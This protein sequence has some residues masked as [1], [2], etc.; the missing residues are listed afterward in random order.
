MVKKTVEKREAYILPVVIL[1]IIFSVVMGMALLELGTTEN[2]RAKRS[3]NREKAFYLAEAGVNWAIA[4]ETTLVEDTTY[5]RSLGDG[6]FSV[7]LTGPYNNRKIESVGTAG[8]AAETVRFQRKEE[9]GQGFVYFDE[10]GDNVAGDV[11]MIDREGDKIPFHLTK[12]NRSD[13]PD[14][15]P[16]PGEADFDD[17]WESEGYSTYADDHGD[18]H[19]G[20]NTTITL[21]KGDHHFRSIQVSGTQAKLVLQGGTRVFIEKDVQLAGGSVEIEDDAEAI[22][23]DPWD[24]GVVIYMAEGV[25]MM[26]TGALGIS[27]PSKMPENFRIFS[28]SDGII[29]FPSSATDFYGIIYA[30]DATVDLVQHTDFHGSIVANKIEGRNDSPLTYYERL[31][32]EEKGVIVETWSKP[33][34]QAHFEE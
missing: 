8:R 32:D 22:V 28:N 19:V 34:W 1:L 27:N 3:G 24:D 15:L 13:Y 33:G 26:V 30:P 31:G 9:G 7:F 21:T 4:Q 16:M 10:D 12:S 20:G 2:T 14:R 5:E 25:D 11:W 18:L 29:K 6:T 17:V 23:D